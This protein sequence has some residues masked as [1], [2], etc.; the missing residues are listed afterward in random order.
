MD[1]ILEKSGHLL[2]FGVEGIVWILTKG[3]RIIVIKSHR[4]V[5][6]FQW[7]ETVILFD[8]YDY[9]FCLQQILEDE[10]ILPPVSE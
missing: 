6:V 10:D 2:D 5:E 7:N 4:I 1:Y 3:R 9:S 8:D